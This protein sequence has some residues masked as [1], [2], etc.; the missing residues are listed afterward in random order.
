MRRTSRWISI[1]L[2][3]LFAGCLLGAVV[4]AFLYYG[5]GVSRHLHSGESSF[6]AG[7]SEIKNNQPTSALVSFHEA[8]LSAENVLKEFET[9]ST[10]AVPADQMETQQRL[11]GQAYWLKY[12]AT[13][14]RSFTRL[15]AENKP[16]PVFEGQGDGSTDQVLHRLS[17]LRIPE[18]DARQTAVQSL[19]EAA[20]RLPGSI[21]VLREAVAMEVQFEPMHWNHVH[22][23][24]TT[25]HDLDP[26][27]ERALFLLARL[28]YEQ[29]V[30]VKV[31]GG[32]TTTP[33]PML[34]R[35]RDRMQKGLE[36][37]AVLKQRESTPRLRTLYLEAQMYAWMLQYYRQPTQLK[38]ESEQKFLAS[39]RQ[40]L[41]DP[42]QGIIARSQKLENLVTAS[43]M[44]VQ[45]LYGLQQMALEMSLADHRKETTSTQSVSA[46]LDTMVQVAEKTSS[47]GRRT[48]AADFLAQA[49]LKAMLHLVA[50]Q[51][52]RWVTFRDALL[53]LANAC[54]TELRPNHALPLRMADLLTR[55]SQWQSQ[56][57]KQDIAKERMQQAKEWLSLGLKVSTQP[58]GNTT[59]ALHEAMLKV[60]LMEQPSR[61]SMQPHLD[62]LRACK[63]DTYLNCAN[64][65]EGLLA[66][67]EGKL[68][69]A[70]NLLERASHTNHNEIQRRATTHLVPI[71]LALEQPEPALK[72]I[73][74]L[75]AQ[76][77]K[78]NSLSTEE[79][80]WLQ[81]MI[82]TPEELLPDKLQAL[83][84]AAQQVQDRA[85]G[86][87]LTSEQKALVTRYETD[88][89]K[90]IS[91]ANSK[92]LASKLQVNWA[93]YLLRH[94]RI[95][96]VQPIIKE[97]NT[98]HSDWLE[99][100][101]LQVGYQLARNSS[102]GNSTDDI[103]AATMLEID[104]SF[105]SYMKQPT[106]NPVAKLLWLQWLVTTN[107]RNAADEALASTT[108]FTRDPSEQKL[109]AL[110]Q[111][112]LGQKQQSHELLKSLPADPQLQLALIQSAQSLTEQQQLLSTAMQQQQQQGIFKAWSAAL[113][114]AQGDYAEACK[115]FLPCLEYT[116]IRPMVRHG[117]TQ[118]MAVWSQSQP[119]EV[120]KF[121]TDALQMYP[122]EPCLLLGYALACQQLGELGSPASTSNQV[123]DMATAL[124]AYEAACQLE[125]VDP[126]Q[127]VW[128]E[129]N[130][131]LMAGRRDI[132]RILAAR[133]LELNPK[134]EVAYPLTVQLFLEDGSA[135]L[136]EQAMIVAQVYRQQF[137]ESMLATFWLGKCLA[138]AGK[139][140]D[141]LAC[142]R[143]VMEKTPRFAQ[144]YAATCDVLLQSAAPESLIACQQVLARWHAAL[145]DDM[146]CVQFDVRLAL[147][148]NRKNDCQVLADRLLTQIENQLQQANPIQT[149]GATLENQSPL[150][151]RKADALC[152]LAQTMAQAGESQS[153][154]QMLSKAV[155]LAPHHTGTL[156]VQGDLYIQQLKKM[157]KH[158]PERKA[159]AQQAINAFSSVYL[160]QKGHV[161]AGCNLAWLL[162][163]ECQEGMEAYRIMQEVRMGKHRTTPMTGDQ[164]ALEALDTM[165]IIYQL[166]AKPEYHAERLELF[167]QAS[168]RYPNDPRIAYYLGQ[169]FLAQSDRRRAL[170]AFQNARTMMV[171]SN[172][173][174]DA[175]RELN[176]LIQAGFKQAE[177]LQ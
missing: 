139:L 74:L 26:Q 148:Q 21:D 118:A 85:L 76:F 146:Q 77:Q 14:A 105:L 150:Q 82:R 114:L 131:W 129:A 168:N 90:C 83:L 1:T 133:V 155:E 64:Y 61:T 12:R 112:Y 18:E 115:S 138:Q 110:A 17:P 135:K 162:V 153:A 175:Q 4:A 176:S 40:L 126:A 65:Y 80:N 71:Y 136:C 86:T 81:G 159:M 149:V 103:P 91:N 22:A 41:L 11:I 113:S 48:E 34:K 5:K 57:T 51:P 137:P 120:R 53:K 79:R 84:L 87:A 2:A 30:S 89:R 68:Q 164:L 119:Q 29:P 16:L 10:E 140:N 151:L 124:K 125:K 101:Q 163:H 6:Q 31:D 94:D 171:K 143:E 43:R 52:D 60:L 15:L 132:A 123:K 8:I 127:P 102:A 55:E 121:A 54:K 32:V 154:Q 67:R 172:Y 152:L 145:P 128:V 116:R 13:K 104:N 157:T 108:L 38:P 166:L 99:T 156:L 142:Y 158:S 63:Q 75:E 147:K 27:D 33:L 45:G 42:V 36:H 170:Q 9:P 69:L 19:R 93:Q 111:L 144:V 174:D 70:R 100:L 97:L 98:Q 122:S 106:A 161:L 25:L 62:A 50:T 66:S 88:A 95:D 44:D 165:G 117:L 92:L 177:E 46:V 160:K 73:A 169:A 47:P 37:I 96:E 56:Q 49:C 134:W 20:Y 7:M 58:A 141:A 72:A 39:L 35:S 109:K 28:E 78:W 3:S 173:S 24:A 107:R 167:H 59:L 23:F 130:C